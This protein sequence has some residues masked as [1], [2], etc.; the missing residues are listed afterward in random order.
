MFDG[1][2][3]HTSLI[4]ILAANGL[5]GV[6]ANYAS[7]QNESEPFRFIGFISTSSSA[8][9]LSNA[10]QREPRTDRGTVAAVRATAGW[11]RPDF[12]FSGIVSDDFQRPGLQRSEW[13]GNCEWGLCDFHGDSHFNP[14][15]SHKSIYMGTVRSSF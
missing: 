15:N 6:N 3:N 8:H 11:H 9:P 1:A 14:S 13:A 12:R 2:D 7:C 4:D 5:S 10:N